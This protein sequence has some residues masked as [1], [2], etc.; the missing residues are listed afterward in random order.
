[1]DLAKTVTERVCRA[2]GAACEHP[3]SPRD[4]DR[5]VDDLGFDSLRIA[6]LAFELEREF[7]EAFLLND[8]I[9]DTHDV[10]DLTVRSLAVYVETC[11][12]EG[13]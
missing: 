11:L 9:A 1:M 8:W 12:A 3:V 5:L 13:A 10:S 7:G 4:T 2:V 6:T